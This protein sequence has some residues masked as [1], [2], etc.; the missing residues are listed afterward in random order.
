MSVVSWKVLATSATL[1]QKPCNMPG[2]RQHAMRHNGHV[3]R[4]ASLKAHC[5][6]YDNASGCFK[7]LFGAAQKHLN[8]IASTEENCGIF[9]IDN[10]VQ[11][12]AAFITAA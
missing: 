8:S 3:G 5:G 12:T 2:K 7:A 10:S 1:L 6:T 9:I 4:S 11:L